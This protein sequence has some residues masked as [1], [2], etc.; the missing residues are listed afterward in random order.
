MFIGATKKFNS[1]KWI[2][3]DTLSGEI[4]SREEAF[5]RGISASSQWFEGGP[6]GAVIVDVIVNSGLLERDFPNWFPF[7]EL[8]SQLG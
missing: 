4:H 3:F 6:C 2:L 8:P 5:G 7:I 1:F